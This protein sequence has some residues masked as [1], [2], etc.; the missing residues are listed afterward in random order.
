MLLHRL[1]GPFLTLALGLGLALGPQTAAARDVLVFAAASLETVL[2]DVAAD[3]QGAT[4]ASVTLSSAASSIL[5]RQIEAG[6]PADIFISANPDWMDLLE[7]DDLIDPRSRID[8]L[9]NSL[10]LIARDPLPDDTRKGAP[11]SIDGPLGQGRI[12]MALV[13][14]VPA[15]QYGRAALESLDLWAD[16]HTKVVQT[17]NVRVAL[18]LVSRG[19][20]ASGIVYATDARADPGVMI[21]E[22]FP[23]GSHP[24]IIYPAA[25]V[26]SS[27]NPA[28]LQFLEYLHS[29]SARA[30]FE[31]HGFIVLAK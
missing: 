10:V 30:I 28:A 26:V 24:P 6:A 14:A 4:G 13:D 19:E 20:A 29:Q 22:A 27:S 31:R 8:L 18:A 17:E 15:G 25:R 21:L 9:G 7:D 23:S 11:L 3:F 2:E 16:L 1:Q 12:A 5:A